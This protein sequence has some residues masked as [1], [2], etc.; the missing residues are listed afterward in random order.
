MTTAAR[1][2]LRWWQ[3]ALAVGVILVATAVR[4]YPAVTSTE[5]LGDELAQEAAFLHQAAG[6]SPYLDGSYVYP[7]SLMR[8]GVVLRQLAA[9]LAVPAAALRVARRAGGPALV[10]DRLARRQALAAPRPRD[11]LRRARAR[12]AP[13]DRVRQPLL[14]RRRVSSSSRFSSGTAPRSR[15]ACCS[16]PSLLVKPLG[17]AALVALF[18]HRPARGRRHQLAAA[19]AVVVA[20]LPLLADPELGN[21]LRHGSHSWVVERTVSL[22]RFLSLARPSANGL[23]R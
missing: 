5:P 21:F 13:G 12:R 16:A 15:A 7:P 3:H 18:F 1:Q 22:H 4:F 14:R 8:L 19:F 23:R 2:H 11:P 10:C 6:R 9:R 20:A 17:L